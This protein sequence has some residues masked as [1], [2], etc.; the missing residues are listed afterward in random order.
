MVAEQATT[1]PTRRRGDNRMGGIHRE[2][3]FRRISRFQGE[4][5]RLEHMVGPVKH[6]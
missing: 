4:R 2:K 1:C 5:S 6:P 3:M